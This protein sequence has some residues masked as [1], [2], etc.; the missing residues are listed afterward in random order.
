MN[1]RA[2]EPTEVLP[3]I[4]SEV[5]AELH[6]KL[7]IRPDVEQLSGGRWRVMVANSRV[8]ATAVFRRSSGGRTHRTAATLTVDSCSRELAAD[9]D[10]LVEIFNYPDGKKAAGIEPMPPACSLDAAP[11]LVKHQ[12]HIIHSRVGDKWDVRLGR[13]GNQYTVG[14]ESDKGV[15]RLHFRRSRGKHWAFDPKRPIQVI[16]DGEDRSKEI[17]GSV[18]RAVALFI[19]TSAGE[20][21]PAKPSINTPAAPARS[22][23]VA[24]R[25]A[26]VI[27]V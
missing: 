19:E 2:D 14:M 8:C 15:L 16:I 22:N 12:Y 20:S 23:S 17:K 10:H 4:V 5:V 25:R 6:Q 24:T 7:G 27:R 13:S 21:S 3:T 1:D 11:V 18:G 26:T 9:D